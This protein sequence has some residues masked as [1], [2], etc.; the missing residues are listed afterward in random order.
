VR[1]AVKNPRVSPGDAGA[2]AMRTI[3]LRY[4][5]ATLTAM[6]QSAACNQ[7][8]SLGQRCARW[9]LA[10]H[11]R[12]DGDT[13]EITNEFLAMMLGVHRPGATIAAQSLPN[14]GLISYQHGTMSILNRERLEV[15]SCECYRAIQREYDRLLKG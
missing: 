1:F 15:T 8:H 14:A 6:G 9:L 12:I 4:V 7:L 5:Q 3:L 11:D 13:F 2:Q 10:A